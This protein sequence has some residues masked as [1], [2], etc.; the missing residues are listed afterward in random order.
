MEPYNRVE[1]F[2]NLVDFEY[3]GVRTSE[4]KRV[5]CLK[6][7]REMIG[8]KSNRICGTCTPK[9]AR[10]SKRQGEAVKLCLNE[11]L[12]PSYTTEY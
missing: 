9:N 8:S 6:C 4:T 11:S 2:K 3:D 12:K 7:G 1:H 5:T 10:V